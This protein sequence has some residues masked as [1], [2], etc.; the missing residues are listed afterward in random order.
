MEDEADANASSSSSSVPVAE[1]A[2][3]AAPETA[4]VSVPV[5]TDAM[6]WLPTELWTNI[7]KLGGPT[8]VYQTGATCS[9]NRSAVAADEVWR[10]F[11]W[12]CFGLDDAAFRLLPM[13]HSWRAAFVHCID[14]LLLLGLSLPEPRRLV[15]RRQFPGPPSIPK[16]RLMD[17]AV[18]CP[19][20]PDWVVDGGPLHAE[21]EAHSDVRGEFSNPVVG[22][23]LVT[24]ATRGYGPLGRCWCTSTFHDKNV[25]VLLRLSVPHLLTGIGVLNPAEGY[26]CPV[27]LVMAFGYAEEPGGLAGATEKAS[28]WYEGKRDAETQATVERLVA[29][30]HDN[31]GRTPWTDGS[32]RNR[33]EPLVAIHFPEP[34]D[35]DGM[36]VVQ[37]C[38][39]TFARY[40]HILMASA[41]NPNKHEAANIDI[42]KLQLFG[43]PAT[44]R[45]QEDGCDDM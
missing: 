15:L 41:Y 9:Q 40:V 28:A 42:S 16:P 26:D 13:C 12:N 11:A 33:A 10:E 17:F 22:A 24:N 43:A 27:K 39:P 30:P 21:V 45:P 29:A 18:R 3:A 35:C 20:E 23:F 5:D 37:R 31:P 44:P 8:T 2:P 19:W 6:P 4:E 36:H 32:Q 38:R 1:A 14:K 25:S 7:V 34:P